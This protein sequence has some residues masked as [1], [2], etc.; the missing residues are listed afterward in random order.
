MKSQ[1]L[2]LLVLLPFFAFA[3][4]PSTEVIPAEK[5]KSPTKWSCIDKHFGYYFASYS[6]AIPTDNL[7]LEKGFVSYNFKAG[8][9]YRYKIVDKFDIGAELAYSNKSSIIK[10]EYISN[11]FNNSNVQKSKLRS[12]HNSADISLFFRYNIG[13]ATHRKLGNF[14]DFG[15]YF[16]YAF[17]YGMLY[18]TQNYNE[19]QK[20]RIINLN[21]LYPE[22]YG[23]FVR[24]GYNY[25][26]FICSYDIR[27]SDELIKDDS[28]TRIKRN[29]L[30]TG[31][32][33]NL[34]AR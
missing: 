5:Y 8:Y 25:I 11:F 4:Y 19:T 3:Q 12:F 23:V 31:I 1:I 7:S 33:L 10:N 20:T 32:Q 14:I 2:F 29:F 30:T 24:F 27:N 18:K 17:N 28:P 9:T 21:Y 26:S 13:G 15:G 16:D 22:N 34:F 6:V